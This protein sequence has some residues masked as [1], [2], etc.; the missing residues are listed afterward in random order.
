MEKS[1]EENPAVFCTESLLS[2]LVTLYD[3]LFNDSM[4]RKR[5]LFLRLAAH[6]P[7][8]FDLFAFGL[9]DLTAPSLTL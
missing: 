6:L 3:F 5:A 9:G 4:E 2:N 1:L 8:D 7:D